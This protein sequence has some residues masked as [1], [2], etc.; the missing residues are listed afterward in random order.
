[1]GT[2]ISAHKEELLNE[3]E[4]QLNL[5]PDRLDEQDCFLLECNFEELTVMTGEH[6]EYWLLAIVATQEAS[7]LQ[8]LRDV[9]G[10]T[11]SRIGSGDGH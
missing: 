5:K 3:I 10:G 7:R 8:Q 11:T 9:M 6:Q 4:C 1:M 2:I